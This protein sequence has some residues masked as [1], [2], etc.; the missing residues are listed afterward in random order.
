[1]KA[2]ITIILAAC[3][4]IATSALS[5][6][7][8]PGEAALKVAL[9]ID[10]SPPIGVAYR[11]SDNVVRTRDQVTVEATITNVSRVTQTIVEMCDNERSW[12]SDNPA[13]SV[14]MMNVLACGLVEKHLEPGGQLHERVR[15]LV[16]RSPKRPLTFR[17][18]FKPAAFGKGLGDSA[19]RDLTLWSNLVKLAH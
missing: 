7:A 5:A 8:V 14:Y 17:L 6:I 10:D 18:G 16:S 9:T 1:M 2:V 11:D 19:L 13:V 15:I 12:E 3:L 4:G